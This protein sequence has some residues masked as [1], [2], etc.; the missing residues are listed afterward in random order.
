MRILVLFI[1]LCVP[2]GAK[3]DQTIFATGIINQIIEVDRLMDLKEWSIKK[4]KSYFP[5]QMGGGQKGDAYRHV[6]ASVLSRKLFGSPIASSSGVVNELL[7]DVKRTNTPRDR[8]M[9]LHNNR[10]GRV[11]CYDELIGK[12]DHETAE[13]VFKF[14]N[15]PGNLVLMDWGG[16]PP[17]TKRAK[18]ES[19]EKAYAKKVILY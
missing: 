3:S 18:Q 1:V 16:M 8:F 15:T 13:K 19:K 5:G 10:V 7:R 12:T 14:F 4:A 17:D 9:D 6:L 11:T 2:I